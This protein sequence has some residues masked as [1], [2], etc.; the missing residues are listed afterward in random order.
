MPPLSWRSVLTLIVL[1][2]INFLD[3]YS[4]YLISVSIIPYV[5]YSSVEYGL[6]SGT[7]FG[8]F[9]ALGGVI[10][11]VQH[12]LLHKLVKSLTISCFIFS[13]TFFFTGITNS[14]WQ[15]ALVRMVMGLG[16]S[17]FTPF[18]TRILASEF[19]EKHRGM[20]FGLFNFS[21]YLAFALV[22]SLGTFMLDRYAY[23]LFVLFQFTGSDNMYSYCANYVKV[24]MAVWLLFVWNNRC[25]PFRCHSFLYKG[26]RIATKHAARFDFCLC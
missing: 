18:S 12:R 4:R 21:I 25:I 10:L 24:W 11:S 14:F 19:T 1:S 2:S 20:V 9:Y 23:H 5:N 22:L 15:L 3:S 7:L 17:I 16:Q 26:A 13:V 6:L 8:V